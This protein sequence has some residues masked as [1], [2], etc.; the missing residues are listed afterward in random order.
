VQSPLL[1]LRANKRAV[2]AVTGTALMVATTIGMGASL[3][4][5]V[6]GLLPTTIGEPTVLILTSRG[7]HNAAGSGYCC[8]NDS[9][10]E[11]NLLHGDRQTWEGSISFEIISANGTQMLLQGELVAVDAGR[12]IDGQ[13]QLECHPGASLAGGIRRQNTQRQRCRQSQSH[14]RACASGGH[15]SSI[16]RQVRR[17]IAPVGAPVGA[18][19][20]TLAGKAAPGF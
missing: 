17:V 6:Q 5:T 10:L 20:V 15:A 8:L 13:H 16:S 12:D 2:S 9:V 11:V 19:S 14:S 4:F 3:F 18:V 7:Y 1:S